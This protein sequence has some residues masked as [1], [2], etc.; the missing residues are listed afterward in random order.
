MNRRMIVY[1]LGMLLLLESVMLLIPALT[2]VIYSESVFKYYIAV[3]LFVALIGFLL[4]RIKNNILSR[5]A[6]NRCT[7]LDTFKF[8]W[9]NT[10][11][12]FGGIS[13]LYRCVF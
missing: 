12:A 8:V 9:C 1:S 6:Y 2:A 3:A 10:N 7:K 5:G 11:V 13:H 4:T